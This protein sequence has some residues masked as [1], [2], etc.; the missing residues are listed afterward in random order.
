MKL[1]DFAGPSAWACLPGAQLLRPYRVADWP[2]LASGLRAV[3][4]VAVVRAT[5]A[6]VVVVVFVAVAG[7]RVL[8]LLGPLSCCAVTVALVSAVPLLVL[9]PGLRSVATAVCRVLVA[10][11]LASLRRLV[12]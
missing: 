5:V 8:V 1:L 11:A 7:R 6:V 3:V 4:V 2:C 12:T 9:L 10:R